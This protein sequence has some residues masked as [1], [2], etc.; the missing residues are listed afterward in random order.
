MEEII[1]VIPTLITLGAIMVLGF[2]GNYI[3]NKTQIP[4]IVWLL[5]F[6]LIVGAIINTYNV[7]VLTPESLGSISPLVGAIAIV[8]ILFD[9]GINT[10]IH[11]LFRGAPRGLMLTLSSFFLSFIGTMFLV[12]FL[13][14]IG[15]INITGDSFVIGA[16]LGAIV[17]GTSSPIVIPLAYR[18]KN[19]QEKTKIV[20]SIESILTDP[21]CI[22]IVFAIAYMVFVVQEINI[23]LGIGNLVIIFSVGIV[24]GVSLGF[25]WLFFMNKIRKAQFS[26]V[27]TLAVIFLVYSFTALIVGTNQGGEGAGAIACLMFGLVLGNGKK[28]LKMVNYQGRGFE[29]D[30]ETKHFHSLVSFIIR[31]FFFVYLGMIVSFY[32]VDYILIGIMVLV[33]LLLLRYSAVYLS[34]YKGGFEKDDMQTLTVMMPRGLAAAILAVKFGPDFINKY[35]P[36]YD[37]FFSDIA[38]VVILGSAIITTF[39]VSVISYYETKKIK[40]V[41]SKSVDNNIDNVMN[42]NNL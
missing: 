10:D 29:M 38:F 15:A 2:I 5:L 20:S 4:S 39:G 6:G 27:I 26:Y 22:V 42:K 34:T 19:L 14:V 41:D 7:E 21:L 30:D 28:I 35:M 8:V 33:V 37:G 18:L 16:V 40:Q 3:F 9:G 1:P 17:G 12:V 36:E 31:T 23:G 32:K 25:I 11:Q 13:D 24:V